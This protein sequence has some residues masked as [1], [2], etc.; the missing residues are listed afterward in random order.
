MEK[1]NRFKLIVMV[2]ACAACIM[3]PASMAFSDYAE[4][5][6][7]DSYY[8]DILEVVGRQD[9]L[10]ESDEDILLE[11]D[12]NIGDSII[13][14]EEVLIT[15]LEETD[16]DEILLSESDD[17]YD[18]LDDTITEEK[19]NTIYSIAFDPSTIDEEILLTEPVLTTPTPTPRPADS[20]TVKAAMAPATGN[21]GTNKSA[22]T[23]SDG[24]GAAASTINTV[25]NQINERRAAEG[26]SP[27]AADSTLNYVATQRV[28]ETSKKFSHT[29]PNGRE[30]VT[31][32]SEYG[33]NAGRSGENIACCISSPEGVVSAWAN[34]P[35]HNRCMLNRDYTRAGV[36]TMVSDGVTYWVL[37]LTN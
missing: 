7:I 11:E 5:L 33:V 30:S 6:S 3:V 2:G 4:D 27:L 37:I 21:K 31:I 22:T 19:S 36:G 28:K 15:G 32:L 29:R 35:S 16:E 8:G 10:I 20:K 14:D 12:S 25:I 1:K 26:V 13:E 17:I 23:A 24:T 9:T 34:S 18:I